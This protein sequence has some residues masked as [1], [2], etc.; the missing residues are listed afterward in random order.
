MGKERDQE[1]SANGLG[2][3]LPACEDGRLW[4]VLT[5]SGGRTLPLVRSLRAAGVDAWTPVGAYSKR[6][7]RSDDRIEVEVA[8]T[9]T[10]VFAAVGSTEAEAA[11]RLAD[12]RR[13]SRALP[14][15]HPDFSIF[16]YDGR[17][18][19]I[20]GKSLIG[21]RMEQ[22]VEQEASR[23]RVE[24]AAALAQAK[25]EAV[26]RQAALKALQEKRLAD[27]KALQAMRAAARCFSAGDRVTTDRS[28][29]TGMVGVVKGKRGRHTL[30]TFGGSHI[31]KIEAWQLF[32]EHVRTAVAA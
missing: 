19:L 12:L 25:A 14:P 28:E 27:R 11:Y 21:L 20:G 7:P 18:P 29:L 1:L 24:H 26:Q 9:P 30:V 10:F 15:R 6:R 13:A 2:S 16:Q 23:Q 22:E 5:T 31:F 32:P 3:V 4:C 17:V 8:I